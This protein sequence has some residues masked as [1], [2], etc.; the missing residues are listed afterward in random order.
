M[1]FLQS[2]G[3]PLI[4]VQKQESH[5]RLGCLK[6]ELGF[7][8]TN[9]DMLEGNVFRIAGHNSFVDHEIIW[10]CVT[11]FINKME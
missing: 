6:S 7:V 8:A 10:K 2:K 3:R 4:W 5:Y 11:S 9:D 1:T